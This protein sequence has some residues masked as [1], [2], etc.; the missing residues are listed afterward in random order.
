MRRIDAIAI[1][2]GVLVAGGLLYLLFQF[3]GL[4]SA[5]AGIWSQVI[6][7][8]GLIGWLMTYVFRAVTG[9]M[10][11][12]QQRQDYEEAVLQKRLEELTPEELAALQAEIEAEQVA[13][14]PKD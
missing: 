10:T 9:S 3:A 12:H 8:S 13:A 5:N 7:V 4:D 14:Q 6:L 11:Y 1:G 2:F